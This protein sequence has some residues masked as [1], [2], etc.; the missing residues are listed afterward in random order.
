MALTLARVNAELGVAGTFCALVQSQVYNLLS[1]CS[2]KI[3]REIHGLGQYIG[4]HIAIPVATQNLEAN[5]RIDFQFI[6]HY[7]PIL[8]PVFAWHNPTAEVLERYL[9]S[10]KLAGLVNAYAARFTREISYFSDSNMR[11][12]VDDFIRLLNPTEHSELQLLLHPLNW[13]AGGNNM[14]DVFS[15]SWPYIIREKELEMLSNHYYSA[16]F[17]SGMPEV[18]LGSFVDQWCQAAEREQDDG[19][20]ISS[21]A[22]LGIP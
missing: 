11:H 20:S 13:V 16:V 21:G 9:Q 3:L 15:R 1:P 7:L 18:V 6:Q 17:P 8:S 4:L 2:Q 10:D 19:H 14:G 5:L 12:S 22:S